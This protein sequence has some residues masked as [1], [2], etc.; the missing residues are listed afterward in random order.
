MKISF[1]SS[2][3]ALWRKNRN[4]IFYVIAFEYI[5]NTHDLHSN[6]KCQPLSDTHLEMYHASTRVAPS[7]D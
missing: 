5:H 7:V 6:M 4:K 3:R 1:P 2:N